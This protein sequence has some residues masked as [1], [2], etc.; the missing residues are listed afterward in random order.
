MKKEY[1]IKE[2][3]IQK[4]DILLKKIEKTIKQDKNVTDNQRRF[5]SK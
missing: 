4:I 5:N 1:K 3:H 2:V